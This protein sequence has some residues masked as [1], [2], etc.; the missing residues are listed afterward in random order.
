MSLARPEKVFPR[1][2]HKAISAAFPEMFPLLLRF[3][4]LATL[5][6]IRRAFRF[7]RGGKAVKSTI[8]RELRAVQRYSVSLPVCLTWKTPS[9]PHSAVNALTRDIST[10]GMFVVS[11]VEVAKGELLEFEIDLGLDEE[12]P[13]VMVRGEGRVVRIERPLH[14]PAGFAVQNVWFRLSEPEQGQ[15][16][17]LDLQTLATARKTARHGGLTIVPRKAAPDSDQNSD[18][19]GPK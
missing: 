17:P 13:L 11:S 10:R 9:A 14:Q 18:Q 5:R 2:P 7:G 3:G 4:S 8:S 15:A 16:L 1:G 12:T 6:L 19:G